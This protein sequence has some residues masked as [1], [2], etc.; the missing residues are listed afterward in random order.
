M[1]PWMWMLLK[2]FAI[3]LGVYFGTLILLGVAAV[4][5]I[6]WLRTL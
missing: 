6:K 3:I 1:N 5:T 4:K 2:P